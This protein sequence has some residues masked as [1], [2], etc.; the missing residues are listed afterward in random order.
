MNR[1]FRKGWSAL[2]YHRPFACSKCGGN[3]FEE[4]FESQSYWHI[5]SRCEDCNFQYEWVTPR[6]CPIKWN[7]TTNDRHLVTTQIEA[8]TDQSG[9][10][11]WV[12]KDFDRPLDGKTTPPTCSS[13]T[14]ETLIQA[15]LTS[16]EEHRKRAE[17]HTPP[18]QTQN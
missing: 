15:D 18:A 14:Y 5:Y 3:G 1:Q 16:F 8:D 2:N 4:L 13:A 7:G 17:Q 10:V 9:Q 11:K 6:S 12:R